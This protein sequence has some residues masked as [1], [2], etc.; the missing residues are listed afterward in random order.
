[1]GVLSCLRSRYRFRVFRRALGLLLGTFLVAMGLELFLI[2]NN[3]IDGGVTGVSIMA[4]HVTHLPVGLFLFALNVPFLWVGYKH[5]GRTFALTTLAGVTLMSVFVSALRP[6]AVIT[7]DLLLAAVFGGSLLGLGVGVVI[8]SGGSLDGT[9][10]VAI[11]LARRWPFTMGEIVMGFN[12]FIL[13]SA[14][15]VFGWDRAMYSLLTYFVAFKAIDV[16]VQGLE[17]SK[18]AMIITTEPD[19]VREALVNRLG[20]GATELEGRGGYSGETKGVLWCVVT[21]LELAKLRSIVLEIDPEAFLAI[22]NVHEVL[23]GRFRKRAIH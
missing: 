9:E 13:G 2:P 16:A 1:M 18:S 11:M 4:G 12:F 5:I 19:A 15:F 3:I 20:R 14:G 7:D 10:I 6:F 22:Q 8:R 21:R 17:E 23:G